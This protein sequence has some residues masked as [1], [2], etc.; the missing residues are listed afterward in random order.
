[1][2]LCAYRIVYNAFGQFE[3]QIKQRKKCN[4]NT[5][6]YELLTFRIFPYER[7]YCAFDLFAPSVRSTANQTR[8][9]AYLLLNLSLGYQ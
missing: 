7:E 5:Q 3:G 6:Q 8:Y 4:S 9:Y 2:A 1:M